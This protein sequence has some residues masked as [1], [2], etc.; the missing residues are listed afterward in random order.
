MAG[1]LLL[2]FF[3]LVQTLELDAEDEDLEILAWESQKISLVGI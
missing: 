3:A 2:W 1:F